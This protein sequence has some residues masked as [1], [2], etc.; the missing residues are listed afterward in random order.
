MLRPQFCGKALGF[1]MLDAILWC[2]ARQVLG[3]LEFSCSGHNLW[4]VRCELWCIRR[5]LET[6]LSYVEWHWV[7]QSWA[8]RGSRVVLHTH[9]VWYISLMMNNR[10]N[11]V[12]MLWLKS[13]HSIFRKENTYVEIIRMC[14]V[15][16]ICL[17]R[18]VLTLLVSYK[19]RLIGDDYQR[20]FIWMIVVRNITD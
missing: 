1:P 10:L 11:N 14:I 13:R 20:R 17:E 6:L 19:R 5:N 9:D 16:E 15:I 7:P 2:R 4:C 8:G 12:K 3:T 18:D